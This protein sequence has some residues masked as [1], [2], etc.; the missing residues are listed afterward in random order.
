VRN[1]DHHLK[2]MMN[3]LYSAH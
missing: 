1:I 3:Y 2:H